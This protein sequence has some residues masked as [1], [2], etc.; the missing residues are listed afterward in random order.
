MKKAPTLLNTGGPK[1][2]ELFVIK[3]IFRYSDIKY[4]YCK[5]SR[6]AYANMISVGHFHSETNKAYTNP[7]HGETRE[8]YK[9]V[10]CFCF[11]PPPPLLLFYFFFL[12]YFLFNLVVE[13][14]FKQ[15]ICFYPL[16]L[17]VSNTCT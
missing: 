14:A 1:N 2:N 6:L 17:Y 4:H 13:S 15:P 11:L 10:F 16:K 8:L 7:S 3:H 5:L 9:G 12:F